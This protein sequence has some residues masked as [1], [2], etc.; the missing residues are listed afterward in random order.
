[1]KPIDIKTKRVWKRITPAGYLSQSRFISTEETLSAMNDS[2][3]FQTVT[4]A[5]FLRE[6][7]PSG[8]SISD[9]TV[10]PDIYREVIVS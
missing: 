4:Q 8:H 7:Y 3:M 5:D 6:F 1:M 10:Y 9:P 2:M